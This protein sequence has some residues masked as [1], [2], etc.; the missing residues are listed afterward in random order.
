MLDM[1]EYTYGNFNKVKGDEFSLS[2]LNRS[3]SQEYLEK[4]NNRPENKTIALPKGYDPTATLEQLERLY[5][6]TIR[7]TYEVPSEDSAINEVY[8]EFAT[9][10]LTA[11]NS[12]KNVLSAKS[13]S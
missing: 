10:S 5:S 9:F 3:K 6:F 7:A 4:S 12:L 1:M 8:T 2:S 11:T 13:V